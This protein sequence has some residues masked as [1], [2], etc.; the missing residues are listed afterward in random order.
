L[1]VAGTLTRGVDGSRGDDVDDAE[2][3]VVVEVGD[4][5]VAPELGGGLTDPAEVAQAGPGVD[6]MNPFRP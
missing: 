4:Q 3:G 6:F 1:V 5:G 2:V